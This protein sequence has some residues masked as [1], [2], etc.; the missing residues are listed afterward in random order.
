M[1]PRERPAAPLSGRAAGRS[2]GRGPFPRG[3]GSQVAL[4]SVAQAILLGRFVSSAALLCV[5]QALCWKRRWTWTS[6][7]WG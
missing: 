7:D 5:L 2:K 4:P 6:V 3:P 1:R